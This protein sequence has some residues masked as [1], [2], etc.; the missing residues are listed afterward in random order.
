MGTVVLRQPDGR[1]ALI[2]VDRSDT[3]G[4]DLT[5]K[6]SSAGEVLVRLTMTQALDLAAR[7][8]EEAGLRFGDHVTGTDEEGRP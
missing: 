1:Q 6:R 7:I 2:M 5:F 8:N 4:I 3:G